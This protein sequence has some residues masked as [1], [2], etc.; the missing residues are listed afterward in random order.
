VL[1]RAGAAFVDSTGAVSDRSATWT[2]A[3]KRV[4]WVSF[5]ASWCGPCKEELPRIQRFVKKLEGDGIPVDVTYVSIDDDLRQLT[6][7]LAQQP[8]GGLKSAYW[9]K[10]GS[11]RAAWLGP[12]KMVSD[13]PLPE[14]G[15]F[16][17]KG[18]LRCWVSG[19]IDEGDYPQI[20][21]SLR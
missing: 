21:A 10:D 4:A 7:F 1:P 18:K 14:H 5:F 16:D 3:S 11:P 2:S 17:A 13:A 15:F 12:L 9:L 19:A 20:V 8:D 6:A